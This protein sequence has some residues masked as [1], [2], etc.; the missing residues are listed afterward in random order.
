MCYHCYVEVYEEQS[1]RFYLSERSLDLNCTHRGAQINLPPTV[2]SMIEGQE[3]DKR[4]LHRLGQVAAVS[5][6]LP[7]AR[8]EDLRSNLDSFVGLKANK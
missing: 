1:R 2:Q 6:N 4:V 5:R 7:V 3:V 8:L